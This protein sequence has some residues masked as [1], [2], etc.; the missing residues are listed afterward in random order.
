MVGE[1]GAVEGGVVDGG[2]A[3]VGGAVTGV[4]G[5]AVVTAGVVL[6]DTA[7]VVAVG[8]LDPVATDFGLW[9]LPTVPRMSPTV[10]IT[11]ARAAATTAMRRRRVAVDARDSD[12]SRARLTPELSAARRASRSPGAG[13]LRWASLCVSGLGK[14]EGRWPRP[15][16][17]LATPTEGT[18]ARRR[19]RGSPTGDGSG[20]WARGDLN[21]HVLADTGT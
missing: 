8:W 4:V 3:V 19:E 17:P 2:D 10:P 7:T 16:R 21:P 5:G 18:R 1:G 11:T 20:P 13:G 12:S 9:L 15:L 6:P 14:V